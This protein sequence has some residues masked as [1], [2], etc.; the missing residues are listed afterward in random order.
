MLRLEGIVKTFG[1]NTVIDG[2][3]LEVKSKKTTVLI[4]SS[5]SGKSTLL[6]CINMLSKPDSGVFE[7]DNIRL[8]F[9]KNHNKSLEREFKLRT[10]MVFQG[11][12]LFPNKTAEEN[13]MLAPVH[14]KGIPVEEARAR[15]NELLESVGLLN[16]KDYYPHALSGGQ[17]QRV[18][19]ARALAMEP[20]IMLFDEPTSALDPEIESEILKLIFDVTKDKF[21]NLI[22]T[23]NMKFAKDISDE[24]V[25]LNNGKI[26][27]IGTF[28]ELEKTDNDR[29]RTFLGLKEKDYV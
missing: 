29:I 17:Q 13:I 21:T 23:H 25:F 2:L 14:V 6:R 10:G 15:A 4:G 1:N 24:V 16:R 18:A 7:Y 12:N 19:I 28:D 5:G 27:F 9:S 26:E 20:E 3:N 8:D 22:V 11:F